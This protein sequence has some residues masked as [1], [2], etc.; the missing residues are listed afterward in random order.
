MLKKEINIFNYF[1]VFLVFSLSGCIVNK[2]PENNQN[3]KVKK[4]NIQEKKVENVVVPKLEKISTYD[5]IEKTY[6]QG[7]IN[8]EKG[9]V[10]NAEMDFNN[11]LLLIYKSNSNEEFKNYFDE[12]TVKNMIETIL[13]SEEELYSFGEYEN[14]T[15]SLTSNV[16]LTNGDE[17]LSQEDEKKEEELAKKAEVTYNIP[18]DLNKQVLSMLKAYSGKLKPVIKKTL[19][20]S[21]IYTDR[22]K[23]I[24]EEEGVP[25][26]LVYL[27]IIES[28]YRINATSRA[29][30]KGIWQFMK[31][32]A[33]LEGLKVNWWVDERCDA[34]K[35]TR[36]AARHLKR[37]NSIYH[38]WY[39]ALAA[40]NAGP[41]KVNRAIRKAKTKDYWKLSKRRW[42]LRKE[43]RNYVAGYLAALI[44]AK[45]PDK[46]GF[47]NLKKPDIEQFE[48]V[49]IDSCTDL[50]V[51][52]KLTDTEVQKL[53]KLNPHL[54]RLTTPPND[55]NF[56][57]NIPLDKKEKFLAKFK[58][59]PQ[60]KRVTIRYYKIRKGQ[61][62]SQIARKFKTSISAIKRANGIRG[63]LIRAGKTIVIPIGKG[64]EIYFPVKNYAIKRKLRYKTGK[65][66]TVKIR[67]RDTLFGLAVKYRTDVKSIKKWNN[68]SSDFL[69]PGQKLTLYYNKSVIKKIK[70]KR[71]KIK[72]PEGY[73]LVKQ[74]DS[75]YSIA[76]AY[77]TD[78]ANI[79]LWNNRKS[80][81]IKPG[82]LIKVVN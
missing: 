47:N 15:G 37:L 39:L 51:V 49:K 48:S 67:R 82:E 26:D 28:G 34:E 33:R 29:K 78:V 62:L 55:K 3:P 2:K 80:N 79:K 69:K 58:Q 13:D 30:A 16:L 23:E 72:I 60:S 46:Y 68:L 20:R 63:N 71:E 7:L 32:T 42:L 59:L 25:T 54:R 56:K 64:N 35:S 61:T 40:Y 8:I 73:H 12:E 19:E 81:I 50:S 75:L 31:G 70:K 77:N 57:L 38:D 6:N 21:L 53:Q 76:R 9:N 45:N 10:K 74:G 14:D 5:L 43:T 11:A 44:I 65:K 17:D 36:A 4:E 52:A 22:F 18:V 1:F 24:F 66:L 27:P 41:G